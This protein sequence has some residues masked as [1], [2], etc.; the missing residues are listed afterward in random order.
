[1]HK[2]APEDTVELVD[3]GV[4]GEERLLGDHL[5]E[6][7]TDGPDVHRRRVHLLTEQDLGR[8]VPQRDHLV[9]VFLDGETEGA[10]QSEVGDLELARI[11]YEQV[12]RLQVAAITV[13]NMSAPSCYGNRTGHCISPVH[14]AA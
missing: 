7:D 9:R 6:D 14:D 11:V 1:V 10:R 12:L 4:A 2:P 5:S 8:A 13:D 3:L